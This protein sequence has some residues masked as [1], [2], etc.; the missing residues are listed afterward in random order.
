ER[1]LVFHPSAEVA[2]FTVDIGWHP[3]TRNQVQPPAIHVKEE[4]ILR[5]RNVSSVQP[6]D[7]VIL[8]FHPHSAHESSFTGILLG[9]HIEHEAANI[10]EKFA[11]DVM[12]VIVLAVK[13]GA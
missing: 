6:D 10:A 3:V 12:K 9:S 2:F 5:R 4:R 7:V 8:I 11:V 1:D 13:I